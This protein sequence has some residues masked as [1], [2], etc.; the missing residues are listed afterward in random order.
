MVSNSFS[1]S[2]KSGQLALLVFF[3]FLSLP[4]FFAPLDFLA[5]LDWP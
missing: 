3:P 2:T 5:V 4:V 1:N